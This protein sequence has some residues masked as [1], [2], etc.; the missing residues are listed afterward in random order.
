MALFWVSRSIGH[1]VLDWSL[2]HMKI[3]R[4]RRGMSPCARGPGYEKAH[5]NDVEQLRLMDMNAI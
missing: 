5:W 3:Y 4:P 1:F 2:G